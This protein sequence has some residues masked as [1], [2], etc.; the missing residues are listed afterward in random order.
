MVLTN[1]QRYT[2]QLQPPSSRDNALRPLLPV[3]YLPTSFTTNTTVPTLSAHT[4][5]PVQATASPS[6]MSH[7]NP[8]EILPEDIIQS[9]IQRPDNL[10]LS[11][12]LSQ[13][14]PD[15]SVVLDIDN[16]T[17]IDIV[18]GLLAND[19]TESRA[20]WLHPP[21]TILTDITN[22]VRHT[23]IHNSLNDFFSEFQGDA[24]NWSLCYRC[25][26]QHDGM[27]PPLHRQGLGFTPYH[28]QS[29]YTSGQR[30]HRQ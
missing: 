28:L 21:A 27:P 4:P 17:A 19:F 5:H 15:P 7:I 12:P 9:V 14:E 16:S 25:M 11:E 2:I 6:S 18:R 24:D 8:S 1:I 30:N 13:P 26:S 20:A 10:Y 22:G 29:E 23:L 3:R